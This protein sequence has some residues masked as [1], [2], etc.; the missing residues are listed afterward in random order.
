LLALLA[1]EAIMNIVQ[2]SLKI[3]Q[4]PHPS[5]KHKARPL[6]AID[7]KVHLIAGAML[8]LMY[9]HRGLGLAGPQ[10]GLPFQMFV[11]NYEADPEN[12][13]VEGVFL[14][15]VI[16]DKKGGTVEAEEGCLSFP[17][18]FQKVRRARTVC[19]QAYDLAGN[20][21]ETELTDLRARIWQH[22]VDHLH[23]I[24]FIDKLGPIGKLASHR[25]L[26]E[27]ER[28]YRKAQGR[29]EIQ[30]DIDIERVLVELE[31]RA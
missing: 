8:E 1:A 11:A 2:S 13:E 6:A 3:V 15:P 17:K 31:Q 18:L 23:G 19:V 21:I 9:E 7:K 16:V 24:L 12:R 27:L 14:N 10:V 28:E 30:P 29:G 25:S 5:L 22:E 20:L 4:Y 26:R